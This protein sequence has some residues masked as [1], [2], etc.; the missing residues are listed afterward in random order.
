MFC[1]LF[2]KGVTK[3]HV[4]VGH[5]KSDWCDLAP[6]ILFLKDFKLFYIEIYSQIGL[7]AT[8]LGS[9]GKQSEIV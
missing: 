8:I 3:L 4:T 1:V 7:V 5:L 6:K 9:A 2:D